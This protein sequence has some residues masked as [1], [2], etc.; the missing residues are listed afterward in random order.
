MRQRLYIK[1]GYDKAGKKKK[2]WAVVNTDEELERAIGFAIEADLQ[3]VQLLDIDV[4]DVVE[5]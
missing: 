3:N 2:V 4:D 1:H 5:I